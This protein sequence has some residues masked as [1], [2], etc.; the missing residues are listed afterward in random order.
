MLDAEE[1]NKNNPSE[2]KETNGEDKKSDDQADSGVESPNIKDAK[3]AETKAEENKMSDA[4]TETVV[5]KTSNG[6]TT[7]PEKPATTEK[8]QTVSKGED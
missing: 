3:S 7:Q 4:T 6:D 8:P 1:R 5:D 2:V